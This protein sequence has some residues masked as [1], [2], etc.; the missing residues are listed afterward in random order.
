MKKVVCWVL[1]I[2][3]IAIMILTGNYLL[4]HRRSGDFT[5]YISDS[6]AIIREYNKRAEGEVVIPGT[7]G[8]HT[9]VKIGERAFA[10]CD[11]LTSVKIPNSVTDIA[12]SAFA[13]CSSL[14][15]VTIPD[16]VISIGRR[17]FF[18]SALSIVMIPESVVSIG[19]SAFL[20]SLES[21][22]GC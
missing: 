19:E 18:S 14:T 2:S 9:V 5:Y 7:L 1:P 22:S 15:T 13:S 8:S 11:Y 4:G 12:E 20:C 10:D 21:L 6:K 17:A 3:V 16:S